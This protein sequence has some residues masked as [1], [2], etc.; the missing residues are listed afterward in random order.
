MYERYKN[1]KNQK[2][3]GTLK[4]RV[5]KLHTFIVVNVMNDLQGIVNFNNIKSG[6][7]IIII[8]RIL[9]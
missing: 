7:N 4:D 3:T 8:H 1:F 6:L 2:P 5:G 9:N